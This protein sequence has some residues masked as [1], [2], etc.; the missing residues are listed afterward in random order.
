MFKF[1]RHLPLVD[2]QIMHPVFQSS[3]VM[4]ICHDNVMLL[5]WETAARQQST[6]LSLNLENNLSL[7]D[8]TS[9]LYFLIVN[10]SHKKTKTSQ[11]TM[12]NTRCVLIPD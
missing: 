2:M 10:K 11:L 6:L 7:K 3:S 9:N 4:F 12:C 1:S 5:T 8:K